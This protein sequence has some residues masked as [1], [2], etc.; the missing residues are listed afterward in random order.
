MNLSLT[1]EI[2]K[3][4]NERVKTGRYTG[5][6]ELVRE[7]IRRLMDYELVQEA[8]RGK[9]EAAIDEAHASIQRGEGLTPE[10]FERRHQQR[11]AEHLKKKPAKAA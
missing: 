3:W 8:A 10:E 9:I 11:K 5:A 6:S 7:A 2:E 4:V 1:P